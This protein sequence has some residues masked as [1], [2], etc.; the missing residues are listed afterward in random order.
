MKYQIEMAT[1]E[2]AE[3]IVKLYQSLIGKDGCTW[4]FDYPGMDDVKN[5]INQKSLYLVFDK[6]V[7]IAAAAAGSD[8]ELDELDCYSKNSKAPCNLARVAVKT[9]Y[10]NKGIAKNMISFIEKQAIKRGFDGIRLLVSKTNFHA[11]AVYD[12]MHYICCG[13]CSMYS[14]EWYCYEKELTHSL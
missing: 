11:R 2:N 3:D 6:G 12:K 13:E 7:I 8:N 1:E 5:D 4:N 14:K 10:Q 9:E